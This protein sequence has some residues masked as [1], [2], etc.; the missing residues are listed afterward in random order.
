MKR[1]FEY[2]IRGKG[3]YA[4]TVVIVL[5]AVCSVT[6]SVLSAQDMKRI[7]NEDFNFQQLQ[8]ARHAAGILT[9]NFKILKG[10]LVTLGLSPSI[11]YVEAVSWANRMKISFSTVRDY[12]VVE[13]SLISAD[14][15]RAY[16]TDSSDRSYVRQV[17]FTDRE[18]FR[19]CRESDNRGRIYASEVRQGKFENSEP[20]FVEMMA[21]PV[22]Q[23]STDDAHPLPT[24]EFA[25]VLVFTLDTGLFTKRV[26]GPI[27]SGKTGYAWVINEKGDFLYHLEQEFIGENAF[28]VRKFKDPHISFGKINLIQKEKMLQGEEGTSWYLS[29]WHRG[30]TGQVKKL[31]A[32]SP[33]RA[34]AENRKRIWS[35]AVVAP[36]SEVEDAVHAIYVRQSLIQGAFIFAAIIVLAFIIS[37][38]RGW[39][40][41]LEQMVEEKTS[42]LEK[43]ASRLKRSQERY[44]SLVE[45]ADDMIYTVDRECRI[46]SVNEYYSRLT[47]QK[48]EEA[49]GKRIGDVI[50]YK[51]SQMVCG[52]VERVLESSATES[53][54]E[55]ARIGDREF[56]LDTKYKPIS[57]GGDRGG[58]VLIISRDVTEH[59]RMEAQFLQ[60]E[61]LASL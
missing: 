29:G 59:R 16:S 3:L 40:R 46:L 4:V 50:Q 12:G 18:F 8:L 57:T 53:H 25:G 2:L 47:G 13:I 49:I 21:V 32:Y 44:R 5:L 14:G 15:R 22:Y 48:G 33:V 60:T 58:Y 1:G 31:I 11:Q 45:S 61:K 30:T 35:V 27:R 9:E 42:D 24:N 56:W 23:V 20:G 51:D 26:V 41:T 10:E 37:I 54:E 55:L 7:I 39:V 36:I 52:I 19:W 28:E 6:L 34:G 43:Y 17:D 38:E